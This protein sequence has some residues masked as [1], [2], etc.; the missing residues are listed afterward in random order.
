MLYSPAG[1]EA[2]A[3]RRSGSL[4]PAPVLVER[5]LEATAVMISTVGYSSRVAVETF[6]FTLE[7]APALVSAVDS[8]S[9]LPIWVLSGRPVELEAGLES[10]SDLPPETIV[11]RRRAC[12]SRSVLLGELRDGRLE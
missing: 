3:S 2:L 12:R 6:G 9:S 4:R 10:T 7:S 11:G 8:T 5:E 1:F